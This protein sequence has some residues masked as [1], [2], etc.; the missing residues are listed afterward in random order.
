MSDPLAARI[1]R[2]RRQVEL[3]PS[4]A[5]LC[6]E[7]AELLELSGDHGAAARARR[8]EVAR[9]PD[10]PLAYLHLARNLVAAG[11][12]PGDEIRL[13]VIEEAAIG[14][15]LAVELDPDF[16]AA[17][18]ELARLDLSR[19]RVL[20]DFDEVQAAA[21]RAVDRCRRALELDPEDA[22]TYRVLGDLHFHVAEDMPKAKECYQRAVQL[23]TEHHDARAMLGAVLER[24]G[25]RDGALREL[26]RVLGVVPGHPLATEILDGIR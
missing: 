7:L 9:R 17:H 1:D 24:S 8:M 18:R 11:A 6:Q 3:H 19:A 22:E 16:G 4:D 15:R 13:P 23:S 26:R 2:L 25:D 20:R 10:R 14:L 5:D 12:E 21:R